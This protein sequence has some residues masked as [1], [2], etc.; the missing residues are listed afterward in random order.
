[1]VLP[2]DAAEELA[3]E[4]VAAEDE[5]ALVVAAEVDSVEDSP[6]DEAALV[7]ETEAL[8]ALLPE[9]KAGPV[10]WYENCLL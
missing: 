4:V 6:V 1:M 2:E 8:A 9:D 10:P 3:E 7:A 5:A